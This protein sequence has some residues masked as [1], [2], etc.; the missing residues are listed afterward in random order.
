MTITQLTT[1]GIS[2][3]PDISGNDIVWVED[4]SDND[5]ILFDGTTTTVLPDLGFSL[6]ANPEISADGILWNGFSSGWQ[7]F[8]Y[9]GTN[10]TQLTN[11][12]NVFDE[13]LSGNRIAWRSTPENLPSGDPTEVF[14]Y[15][16][17]TQITTQLT[18]NNNGEASVDISGNNVVW[19]GG[20]NTI[21]LHDGIT[22]T[23]LASNSVTPLVFLTAMSSG[24][25]GMVMI[26]N[27]SVLMALIHPK[28]PTMILMMFSLLL[29][30]RPLV[31]IIVL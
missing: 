30:L 28:L 5:L 24:A 18:N 10:N 16:S 4:G 23:Q 7:I 26:G 25:N 27:Y 13:K 1:N 15:D 21:L 17:S 20:G 8:F 31:V 19:R 29:V 11:A 2:N 12:N 6:I 3:N 9:D 14:V 22:T